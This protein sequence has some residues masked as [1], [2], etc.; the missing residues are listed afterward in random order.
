MYKSFYRFCVTTSVPMRVNHDCSDEQH[1]CSQ[2]RALSGTIL[3]SQ[4]LIFPLLTLDL[5]SEVQAWHSWSQRHT[6]TT[7]SSPTSQQDQNRQGYKIRHHTRPPPAP[8][9]NIH[10]RIYIHADATHT[11]THVNHISIVRVLTL[12]IWYV[13][14]TVSP[15]P[16]L[17]PLYICLNSSQVMG[18]RELIPGGRPRSHLGHRGAY[19]VSVTVIFH[20]S[21][22]SLTVLSDLIDHWRE[23]K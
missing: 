19:S 21:E 11:H 20:S 15:F 16:S 18:Y 17:H 22:N 2:A 3:V 8:R 5:P 13:P 23:I 10:P 14:S 1:V 4:P 12:W 7:T 6:G 9:H